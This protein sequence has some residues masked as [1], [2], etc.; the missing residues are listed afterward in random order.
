MTDPEN[1]KNAGISEKKDAAPITPGQPVEAAPDDED[2]LNETNNGE[3]AD[4]L[5][6]DDAEETGD[7]LRGK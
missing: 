3:G 2:E 1:K 5:E 4:G 7:E 6:D